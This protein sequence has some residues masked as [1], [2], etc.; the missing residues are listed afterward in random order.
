MLVNLTQIV[1]FS[2]TLTKPRP[3]DKTNNS[4]EDIPC[5]YVY[6]V[7][8][9]HYFESSTRCCPLDIIANWTAEPLFWKCNWRLQVVYYNWFYKKKKKKVE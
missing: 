2:L 5:I 9:L 4:P 3:F 1:T 8:R 7:C 6:T